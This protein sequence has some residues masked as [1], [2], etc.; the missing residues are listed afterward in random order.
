[1]ELVEKDVIN[2]QSIYQS[3]LNHFS[4]MESFYSI[5]DKSREKELIRVHYS[6]EVERNY[7]IPYYFI[8]MFGPHNIDSIYPEYN[9]PFDK[10]GFK[11]KVRRSENLIHTRLNLLYSFRAYML[12]YKLYKDIV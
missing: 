10:K 9:L 4:Y 11:F 7:T 5:F 12:T 3:L 8:L 1:M 6:I 2:R